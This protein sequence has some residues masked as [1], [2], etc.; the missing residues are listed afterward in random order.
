MRGFFQRALGA[1]QTQPNCVATN[2]IEREYFLQALFYADIQ[3]SLCRKHVFQSQL[4]CLESLR[5]NHV[6]SLAI[7]LLAHKDNCEFL[8]FQFREAL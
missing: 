7:P 6:S 8:Y 5:H 4:C 2:T 1:L 3:F